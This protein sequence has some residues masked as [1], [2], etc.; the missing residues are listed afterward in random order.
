[1]TL[2]ASSKELHAFCAPYLRTPPK[3]L[4]LDTEFLRHKTYRPHICL[5]QLGL[6]NRCVA[7]DPLVPGIDLTPLQHLLTSPQ[8]VKIAHAMGQDLEGLVPLVGAPLAPLFDTQVAAML[9]DDAFMPSYSAL[10]QNHHNT[11]LSKEL[12]RHPWDKRPLCPKALSYALDDVRYLTPLYD[13]Y[14]RLLKNKKRAAWMDEEMQTLARP[15]APD[16]LRAWKKVKNWHLQ[17]LTP[18]GFAR[19]KVVATWREEKAIK[20]NIPR[21]RV[22]ADTALL[23]AAGAPTATESAAHLN[24][25]KLNTSQ[26]QVWAELWSA[27]NTHDPLPSRWRPTKA[28]TKK[29]KKLQ[30][31]ASAIAEEL[32]MPLPFL[33]T[34]PALEQLANGQTPTVLEG[35]T[36]RARLMK[37]RLQGCL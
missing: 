10:V 27:H 14:V 1:L 32:A 9:T 5:I 29:V 25:L 6:P 13:H 28:D 15:L 30:Q 24:A 16:L 34:R 3:L 12:Q 20:R 36:W 35:D 31:E 37:E 17:A 2:I 26:K 18:A 23:N 19:L 21:N 8:T 7:I 4:A 33:I 22:I 11:L